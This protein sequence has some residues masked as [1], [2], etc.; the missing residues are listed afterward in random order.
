[1]VKTDHI[2]FIASG[3]FHLCKPSDLV[4]ELQGRFP[5]RVELSGLG[6]DEFFQILTEPENA[7]LKQYVALMQTEGIELVFEE[8][9][10][11]EMARLAAEVNQKTEDIGARRLHT[12]M[13][14]VLEDLLFRASEIQDSSFSITAEYVREQLT[15]IIQDEDLSRF[16]L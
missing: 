13:E 6:E 9:A 10:V 2:L 14:R 4:P 7:L 11:R 3:A 5:I 15:E 8:E 16:I 1:M 12:I